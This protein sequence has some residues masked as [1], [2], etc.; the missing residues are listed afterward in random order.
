VAGSGARSLTGGDRGCDRRLLF[1]R[2]ACGQRRQWRREIGADRVHSEPRERYRDRQGCEICDGPRPRPPTGNPSSLIPDRSQVMR[3]AHRN[4]DVARAAGSSDRIALDLLRQQL[5]GRRV[6]EMKATAG[7]ALKCLVLLLPIGGRGFHLQ[8]YPGRCGRSGDN[9][10]GMSG[11][12]RIVSALPRIG[13]VLDQ[14]GCT[15]LIGR[16]PLQHCILSSRSK[17]LQRGCLS[18]QSRRLGFKV[19]YVLAYHLPVARHG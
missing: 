19:F 13:F 11:P 15:A 17:S 5:Q 12:Y 18:L 7:C 16:E 6:D 9:S 4:A 2:R 8:P 3:N 14:S 10:R 1:R